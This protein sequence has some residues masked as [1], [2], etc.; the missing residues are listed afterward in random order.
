M[1]VCQL[2]SSPGATHVHPIVQ[3]SRDQ[4]MSH[5]L[6]DSRTTSGVWVQ[7]GT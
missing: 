1:P 5:L 7:Q 3:H 2:L 4:E 6:G